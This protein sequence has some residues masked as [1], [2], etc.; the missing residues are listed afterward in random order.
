MISIFEWGYSGKKELLVNDPF[1]FC[2]ILI[3]RINHYFGHGFFEP[4][5]QIRYQ[6]AD[7]TSTFSKNLS[8]I[9]VWY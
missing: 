4:L 3:H 9:P 5:N 8:T 2:L 1:Q 6:L 7:S